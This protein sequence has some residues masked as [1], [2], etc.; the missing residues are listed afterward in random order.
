MPAPGTFVLHSRAV[1]PLPAGDY[2]L[3]GTQ[4]VAGGPTAPYSGS[5]RVTSARYRMP[6]DQIL[7][8]FPPANAEG[9][10][11]SRLPQMVI[12]RRTLPWERVVDAAH[13]E[14]PWIAL[15][16]I[17]EGEG[18][19][20]GESPVS[21]CVTPGVKLDGP[22]DVATGIYLSVSQT[23][24][25]AVFPTKDD[26]Q[27]L[28]HV[29]EVDLSD[30]EL[31][32]GDDDGFLA[33]MMANRLP[34]YDRVN[35]QPVRYMA[36]LIS[37]EG[38]LDVLPPQPPEF[39][40]QFN[41]L[42]YVQDVRPAAALLNQSAD[43]VAMGPVASGTQA[44]A[45]KS[46]APN[47]AVQA[48]AAQAPRK[49]IAD[50]WK[51]TQT[52]VNEI[53]VSAAPAE[54][55]R[56]VRDQMTANFRLPIDQLVFEKTYR[57]PLLAHWSFTCTGAGSFQ[58]LME[59]LDVGLLG[60]L[61]ADPLAPPKPDCA[62]ANKGTAPPPAPPPR[63]AP[64]A[65]ETGHIGL[66]NLTRRGDS[67]RAW[68]RGPL[69]LHVTERE[70]PDAAGRLPLAHTSDQLR[71][72][73]PDGREDLSLAAAFEIGRL[74]AFSQPSVMT[75]LIRWRGEQFGAERARQMAAAAVGAS[76]LLNPALKGSV[77]QLG[78]LAGRQ[79][80]TGAAQA[81][82]KVLAPNRPLV[83]PGRPIPYLTGDVDQIIA[84]GFNIPLADVRKVM[85]TVGPVA[86]LN[87]VA[88][89]AAPA[90]APDAAS[91]IHL[92][93]TLSNVVEQL[94]ANSTLKTPVSRGVQS[95]AEREGEAADAL[96]EL[97]AAAAQTRSGKP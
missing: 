61:P 47:A 45:S 80:V 53:A 40:L 18:Q 66:Q 73:T 19:V 93:A 17:A 26:L 28:T 14:I 50:S 97:L 37:L 59:G 67:L 52:S 38:Q 11:E 48:H 78:R 5:L 60:T 8:T 74:L 64:E 23:V 91:T 83:D 82:D 79:I 49:M 92:R 89:Q 24:V 25:N 70:Q 36:C 9:A 88:V 94:T 76:A 51:T 72:V 32:V 68:Y 46:V 39:V 56:L 7:S 10:F 12:K 54:A 6:P 43:Q 95:N 30:T 77:E 71:R 34:Q 35:C 4:E 44:T 84:T 96:D 31:A 20:S 41:A 13:R 81:P 42:A 62:P 55:G 3:Q 27:L 22:N 57:F 65:T 90:P 58:S 87:Q 21:D 85:S 2:T 63:P 33:V 29:R 86:A 69:T 16:V 1:P 75:A 15:V